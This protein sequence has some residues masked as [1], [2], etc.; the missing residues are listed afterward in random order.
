MLY[1][2][3]NFTLVSG[4]TVNRVAKW[5]G[6]KWSAVGY[7]FDS[8]T[9]YTLASFNDTLYAGGSFITSNSRTVNHISRWTGKLWDSVKS[10]TNK[11]VYVIDSFNRSLYVG[12][13]FTKAGGLKCNYIASWA[14]NLWDSLGSGTNDTVKA[15]TSAGNFYGVI[16]KSLK[17]NGNAAA[18]L[19]GG[20]FDKAG[21]LPSNYVALYFITSIWSSEGFSYG[22]N[23]VQ[24]LTE[25]VYA[26]TS[27][28]DENYV[29]GVFDTAF[30]IDFTN[31]SM[32]V[33]YIA[34]FSFGLG[35][36]IDELSDNGN[37]SVMPNP[38]NG[39]FNVQ[40]VN[41]E[42]LMADSKIE[43]YNMLDQQIANSQWPLANSSMQIDIS[44][45]PSGIYLYRIIDDNSRVIG[46]G[47]LIIEK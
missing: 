5:N 20:S 3:G 31:D 12:G 2:G 37:I 25:P 44:N 18:L 24:G 43:I 30:G 8:N 11:I 15:M 23:P 10:G 6:S 4:I 22:W 41:S 47:K 45:Q 26:V 34:Q 46:S 40:I 33:N 17:S 36:G 35:G 13:A 19:V 32:K 14:N 29:G 7:G 39:I 38:S 27:N 42:Q 21:N 28:I 1:V 16:I 9:V